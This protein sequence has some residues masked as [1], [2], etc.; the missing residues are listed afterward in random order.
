MLDPFVNR[1]VKQYLPDFFEVMDMS[2]D[3]GAILAAASQNQREHRTEQ[4]GVGAW[5]QLKMKIGYRG[6]FS[7]ARIDREHPALGVLFDLVEVRP[8][9]SEAMRLVRIASQYDQQI[10]VLH[11][12][13]RMAVLCAKEMTVD[14]ESRRSFPAPGSWRSTKIPSH[15]SARP[16]MGPSEWSPCPPPP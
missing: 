16:H 10:A 8:R 12:L 9:R 4:K 11:V 1:N 3:E 13:G 14:P 6:R 15:A 7:A 2:V 5:T